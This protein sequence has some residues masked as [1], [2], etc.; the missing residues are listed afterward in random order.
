MDLDG[1]ACHRYSVQHA[2]GWEDTLAENREHL[3]RLKCL[4]SWRRSAGAEFSFDLKQQALE[5]F[6]FR[7]CQIDG[8]V[9]TALQALDDARGTMAVERGAGDDFLEQFNADAAGT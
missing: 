8:M 2:E 9:C 3:Y 7:K 5:V 4:S 6:A 1:S